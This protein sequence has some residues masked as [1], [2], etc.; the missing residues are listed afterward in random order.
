[1]I[2]D[3][4]KEDF[5][6]TESSHGPQLALSLAILKVFKRVD[7]RFNKTEYRYAIAII[8]FFILAHYLKNPAALLAQ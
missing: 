3:F 4:C 6:G 7:S 1:M 2:C 5:I 8:F